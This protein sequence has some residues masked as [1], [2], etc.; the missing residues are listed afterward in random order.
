M[1]G[2]SD[3]RSRAPPPAT[4]R[5]C[6]AVEDMDCAD[7]VAVL[8]GALRALVPG[9]DRLA[10]D[11][12]RGRLWVS[13]RDG[14]PNR[15]AVLQAVART[16]MRATVCEA[17]APKPTE[18][19]DAALRRRLLLTAA[20]GLA[21][22]AGVATEALTGSGLARALGAGTGEHAVGTPARALYAVTILIAYR[23]VAPRAWAALRR[24]RPDMNL[25]MSVAVVGALLI[26]E[27][28]EAAVVSFLFALSLAIESW[29]A[30]RARRAVDSILRLVPDLVRVVD[31][32]GVEES[33]AP[34]GVPLGTHFVVRPGERVP[35][36]GTVIEGVSHI[37]EAPITGES[38][39]V[40]KSPSSDVF[41]G[42]IN[43]AGALVVASTHT[44]GDTVLARVVR[45]IAEAGSQ[46]AP[47]E[48]WV[49]RFAAVYTPAVLAAAL[50]VAVVPPIA[51]GAEWSPWI[52][53]A[54]VLLVVSC[55]CAL[56][57]STP[58]T[59]VS[60]LA[61]AARGG[62]LVKGS[63]HLEALASVRAVALDKTGTLS[64]GRPRVV[65][66][67][68][69]RGDAAEVLAMAASVEVRSEHPLARAVT[70]AAEDRALVFRAATDFVAMA[71][72]GARATV[73][74]GDGTRRA[75]WIGS[76]AFLE[77]LGLES[78]T[79]HERLIDFAHGGRTVVVVGTDDEVLG[80]IAI[81]DELREESAEAVASL[82]RLGIKHVSLLT[83][84]NREA[85]AVIGERCGIDD[86]RAELLP[87][88]KVAE[89]ERLLDEHGFV[90]MV[91]DGV[92]D[93][94]ALAR[95]SVGIAMG[96][97]GSD[98]AIETADVA[99]MADDL[100]RLPW[101]IDLSRRALR[102][103]RTN[104]ALSL[105]VKAAFIVM[106]AVGSASLWAAIAADMGASL[107]VTLN[108]LTLLRRREL[109]SVPL[110]QPPDKKVPRLESGAP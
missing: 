89:I 3:A 36:D 12:V 90:A 9:E 84:D 94:P 21:L 2:D 78:R 4:D 16:G 63:G 106:A 40:A 57:I 20:S 45:T 46:R 61:A 8:R 73:E 32:A 79:V 107:V 67:L 51:L 72:K 71:G 27:W 14:E 110:L 30:G 97:A 103:V 101:V 56:V 42:T 29:S 39:P 96:A 81:A 13:L 10:F 44:A 100:R 66:V 33:V 25:L 86:V 99:L 48:R 41:A 64:E 28:L 26:G 87:H 60:A 37:D 98:A 18:V 15:Q 65:E 80:M 17:G 95:A 49:D 23:Y 6:F 58:V 74:S 11:V 77:E 88:D 52:Y 38:L 31:A 1:T 93:A 102:T 68:A 35:L 54:L 5:L 92:N 43:G 109:P 105:S 24:L 91:G 83:G 50:L 59:L 69:L 104:V 85:A 22:S 70:R 7:E 62:V 108:G 82:S 19:P 75:V 47:V 76:H 55:P 34:D 53:R